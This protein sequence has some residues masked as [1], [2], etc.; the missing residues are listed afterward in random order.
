MNN[1]SII[2][3][4]KLCE[5]LDAAANEAWSRDDHGAEARA[6]SAVSDILGQMI[7]EENPEHTCETK[8]WDWDRKQQEAAQGEQTHMFG[9]C[10][11]GTWSSLVNP[12]DK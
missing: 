1:E 10:F 11:I 9:N 6:L 4:T 7:D 2:F 3:L 5:K 12:F 8:P